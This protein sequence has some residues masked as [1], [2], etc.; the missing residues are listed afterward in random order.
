MDNFWEL[1]IVVVFEGVGSGI[2]LFIIIVLIFDCF[3]L[4]ERGRVF[5]VCMSGFDGGIVIVVFIMGVLNEIFGYCYVFWFSGGLVLVVIMVF[6]IFFNF[7]I[8]CFFRFCIG[9]SRD[10]YVIF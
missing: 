4:E 9:C 3:F 2:L 1:L 8:G 7:I 5:F 10:F 6:G